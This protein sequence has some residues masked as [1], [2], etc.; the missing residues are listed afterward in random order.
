MNIFNFWYLSSGYCIYLNKYVRIGGYCSKLKWCTSKN[1][2]E[3]LVWT[4]PTAP[5]VHV[6]FSRWS[7]KKTT[8]S[9]LYHTKWI[10]LQVPPVPPQIQAVPF[11]ICTLVYE[12]LHLLEK[13]LEPPYRILIY[14]GLRIYLNMSSVLEPSS[15]GYE[16]DIQNLISHCGL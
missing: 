15:L 11:G 13:F 14:D 2:W 6:I 8:P 5:S 1:V 9:P 10:R 16:S 4:F 7:F 3:T 12:I